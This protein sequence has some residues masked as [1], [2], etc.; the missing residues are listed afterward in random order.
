MLE[1]PGGEVFK[2]T[3]LNSQTT[4]AA[5]LIKSSVKG[6]VSRK[7]TPL[8]RAATI[9]Q[10]CTKRWRDKK[11]LREQQEHFAAKVLQKHHR[12]LLLRLVKRSR[13]NHRSSTKEKDC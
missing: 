7:K 4:Q 12:K 8:H 11:R 10:Q 9:L 13:G 2:C 6:L 1:L 3:L 5:N